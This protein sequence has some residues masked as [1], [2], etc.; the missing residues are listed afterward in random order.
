MTTCDAKQPVESEDADPRG[1]IILGVPRSGTTLL[2][3]L[4][5]WHPD[6]HCGGETFLLTAAARFLRSDRIV[7]GID[8]GVLGGLAAAGI[9]RE[10]VLADLRSLVSSYFCQL[11]AAAGKPRW[12]SKTAV[13][14]FYVPEI[15]SLFAGHARFIC[16]VRHGLDVALSLKDL[17][18]ANETYIREIHHYVARYARPLEAFSH[19][20]AETTVSMLD[21][22]QRWP[23][24]ALVVRYEDLVAQPA[25]TLTRVTGFLGLSGGH[26]LTAALLNDSPNGLG[27]WKTY[28]TT[29]VETSSAGRWRGLGPAT[30]ALVSPVVN[31]VLE[32][33]GYDR[34]ESGAAPT[35]GE[36]MRRYELSMG[37]QAAR[38][39]SNK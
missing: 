16:L 30:L 15:E 26:D 19:A 14:S 37:L 5:N 4:L 29:A 20:W 6:V 33:L 31:P 13:D 38:S 18:E 3:R 25:D 27:D 11:A 17:C 9:P 8:Y 12:A 32:R 28:G 21:F 35:P 7:D 23:D 39:R 24:A 34:I 2:R 10:K 36:A 1:I 22:A